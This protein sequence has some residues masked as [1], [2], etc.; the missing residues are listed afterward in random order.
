MN[1]TI[2]E[3]VPLNLA[4]ASASNNKEAQGGLV[5]SLKNLLTGIAPVD[6]HHHRNL[7]QSNPIIINYHTT[8]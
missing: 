2:Y 1:Y 4:K 7:L 3:Y 6:L 5:N 8:Y